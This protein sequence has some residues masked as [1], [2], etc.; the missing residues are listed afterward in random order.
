MGSAHVAK[1]GYESHVAAMLNDLNP[2]TVDAVY[3]VTPAYGPGSRVF[4]AIGPQNVPAEPSLVSEG[5]ADEVLDNYYLST[6]HA[7]FDCTDNPF[8]DIVAEM[9][10][11]GTS[12]GHWDAFFWFRQLTPDIPEGGWGKGALSSAQLSALES[13]ERMRLANEAMR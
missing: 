7:G 9:G 11:A 1:G 13:V 6:I 3:T 10:L 4:Y 8:P 2:S 5:L 12:Y